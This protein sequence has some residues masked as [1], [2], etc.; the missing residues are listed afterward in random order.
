MILSRQSLGKMALGDKPMIHGVKEKDIQ[1]SS[2]D[3]PLGDWVY[4]VEAASVPGRG[5]K[6]EELLKN[7]KY[8]FRLDEGSMLEEGA[9]YI[10]PLRASL[11]LGAAQTALFSPKSS[12]GRVD[13]FVRVIADGVPQYDRVGPGYEGPLYVEVTPQSF[14]VEIGPNLSLVQLRIREGNNICRQGELERVHANSPFIFMDGEP[15]SR[16]AMDVYGSV[17]YFHL[18][19]S[20]GVVGFRARNDVTTPINLTRVDA[21]NPRHFWHP[22]FQEDIAEHVHIMPGS[23]Y[24]LSSV[25]R[26]RVPEEYCGEVISYDPSSGDFRTHYAGFFDN[27]FGAEHGSAMVLEVRA[28]G[29][30]PQRLK[31]GFRI[32]GMEFE[33]TDQIPDVLYGQ[34][35]GSH[36]T[37]AGPSL[38]KHFMDRYSAWKK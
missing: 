26:V 8:S 14:D 4:R 10:I 32:C 38:S 21:Y 6:V 37:D 29:T 24:L 35:L 2:I 3:L 1:T 18:D 31:H 33:Q 23:F 5:E 34:E 36:Y 28:N 16:N 30:V 13:V 20:Q 9:V 27:G 12:I 11:S 15:I 25:E 22:I 7:P 17:A 19:L